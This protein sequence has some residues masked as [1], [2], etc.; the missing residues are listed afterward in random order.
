MMVYDVTSWSYVNLDDP[1]FQVIA[2][3]I[4]CHN[5]HKTAVHP[6]ALFMQLAVHECCKIDLYLLSSDQRNTE[7]KME[8]CL[9]YIEQAEQ[10]LQNDVERLVGT[11]GTLSKMF[12]QDTRVKSYVIGALTITD[13]FRMP[14]TPQDE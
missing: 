4:Y 6:Y 10:T 1:I 7:A 8:E 14:F 12:S 11:N 13:N 5:Y 2:P 3:Y 9:K